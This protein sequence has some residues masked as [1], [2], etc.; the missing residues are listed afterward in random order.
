MGEIGSGDRQCREVR[1]AAL[2]NEKENRS[3][4]ENE[5]KERSE[6]R[7][8]THSFELPKQAEREENSL[9]YADS[10]EGRLCEGLRSVREESNDELWKH[11]L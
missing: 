10:P 5:R 1:L 8:I 2:K 9:H 6:E 3:E 4:E 11:L 7:D